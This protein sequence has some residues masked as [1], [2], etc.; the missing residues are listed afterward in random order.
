VLENS[1]DVTSAKTIGELGLVMLEKGIW[2]GKTHTATPNNSRACGYPGYMVNGGFHRILPGGQCTIGEVL[3]TLCAFD[4]PL[5]ELI[6]TNNEGNV[7]GSRVSGVINVTCTQPMNVLIRGQYQGVD[8]IILDSTSNFQSVLTVNDQPLSSG[9]LIN[10]SPSTTSVM[11]TS[12]LKGTPLP[13]NY[14]GSTVI[15]ISL[16]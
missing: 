6:H 3:P 1:K 5:L 4:M 14:Q 10:A 9:V 12:T 13:G 2:F 16:P 11:V 7:N 8:A 15:I